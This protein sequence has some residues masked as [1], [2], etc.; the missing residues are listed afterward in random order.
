MSSRRPTRTAPDRRRAATLVLLGALTLGLVGCSSPGTG[1]TRVVIVPEGASFSEVTDSLAARG[2]VTLTPLFSLYARVR[3]ADQD[4][5]AGVYRFKRGVGWA[6]ILDDLRHG[7][8]VYE[9]LVIPE[10]WNAT[11]DAP[12]IAAI[13][14]LSPDSVL[15][16]L[17][18]T[19]EAHRYDVPGPTLEGYLYPATYMFPPAAPLDTV[20]RRMTARYREAWTPA[21]R[22]AADSLGLSER[23]V[24]T[25]AS[26]VER[27]AKLPAEMPH[28]ASVYLNRLHRHMLLQADPTVQYALGEHH[29]R[30][31]Y[32][33]IDSVARNPYNTYTHP[34][35]PPGPIASPSARALDAVLHADSTRDLYFVA[36]PS[37]SHIFSRTLAEH[38]RAIRRIRH[39][40]RV[41]ADSARADSAR[42]A[43]RTHHGGRRP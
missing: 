26:I 38:K 25:L 4:A 5:K 28:I 33:E 32:V 43:R 35:L 12:R 42:R 36:T 9:R 18:D 14:R 24:V 17:R 27:E 31:Y 39:M 40:E 19:A 2:L 20:L 10:A 21:R 30:L 37:G 8:G 29:T 1:P 16:V 23:A 34:G 13:T 15:R 7:R 11:A 22:A 3:G 6:R 41:A